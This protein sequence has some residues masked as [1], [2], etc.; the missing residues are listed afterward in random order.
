MKIK[1]STISHFQTFSVMKNANFK[2]SNPFWVLLMIAFFQFANNSNLKAQDQIFY[3]TGEE[4]LA[5]V[6]EISTTEVKFK[7]WDNLE[8]PTITITKTDVWMIKYQNGTKD[9][10]YKQTISATKNK[11]T[12]TETEEEPVKNR[13]PKTSTQ[14][15]T[16]WR[17]VVEPESNK[18]ANPTENEIGT[19]FYILAG[20]SKPLGDFANPDLGG[21]K[22]GFTLGLEEV[23]RFNNSHF[24]GV[25]S[26]YYARNGCSSY[27]YDYDLEEFFPV[28]GTYQTVTSLGGFRIQSIEKETRFYA[29]LLG[30]YAAIN[31]KL[32]GANLTR[33]DYAYALGAGVQHKKLDFSLR[34]NT[35]T[36]STDVLPAINSLTLTAGVRF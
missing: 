33:Y 27:Y 23:Y 9:L 7:K 3:K 8:G 22:P 2:P 6:L 34:Y 1:I 24:H 20:I 30:G 17:G 18:K 10:I 5:K 13:Q 14:P 35:I 11:S 15:Q 29:T 36:G 31:L 32:G 12:E 21:A 4:Q 19:G 26:L 16:Q 25:G 28:Q